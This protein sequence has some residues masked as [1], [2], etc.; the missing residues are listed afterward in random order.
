MVQSK[1]NRVLGG[2]ETQLAS[3]PEIR[4]SCEDFAAEWKRPLQLVER[5]LTRAGYSVEQVS[6]L[7]RLRAVLANCGRDGQLYRDY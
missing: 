7:G 1:W 2:T 3:K 6:G 4:L 5:A